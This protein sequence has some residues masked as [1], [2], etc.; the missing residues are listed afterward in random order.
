MS[1]ILRILIGG[2]CTVLIIAGLKAAS[3]IVGFVLIAVM[4]AISIT[5]VVIFLTNKGL[6]RG[7]SLFITIF[8]LLIVGIMLVTLLGT[9]V[10]ELS[11]TLPT[12]ESRMQELIVSIDAV[13]EK[14]NFDIDKLIAQSE[15]DTKRLVQ[16]AT[17]LL[18]KL[19]NSLGSGIFLIIV[20]SL[21]VVEFSGYEYKIQTGDIHPGSL[22][23]RMYEVRTE[24]RKF[25]SITAL[26]GFMSSVCNVILLLA[27]GVEFA[28]LWGVLS[29]FFNF[30]PVIGAI[31]ALLPPFLLA[32]IQFGWTKAII[33]VV[34]FVLF[35]N[36]ADNVIKPKLM[37]DGLNISILV[38]FLSLFFWNWVLGFAGAILAIPLT[39][40]I[41]KIYAE[42][43]KEHDIL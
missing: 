30:I 14:Y 20:V 8:S 31:L 22:S 1:P 34:G 32:L 28:V 40:T 9:S 36:I 35:N 23:A 5:P 38:I 6:K 27:L 11:T 41:T 42:L 17:S 18:S 2:A 26:T 21:M 37:K 25:L 24:I 33:V 29:F 16:I 39:I 15:L 7:L 3:D 10:V 19:G 12:Y 4:L 43:S 13:L